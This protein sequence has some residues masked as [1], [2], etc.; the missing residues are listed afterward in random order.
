MDDL[1]LPELNPE[2]LADRLDEAL[3]SGRTTAT[4]AEANDPRIAIA[5][6]LANSRHPEMSPEML[7]RIQSKVIAAH[8]QQFPRTRTSRPQSTLALRWAAAAAMVIVFLGAATMPTVASSVPGDFW[9]PFKRN[10]ENIELLIAR[11][12]VTR[13]EVHLTQAERRINEVQV[14][15]QRQEFDAN[16]MID[17]RH[18]LADFEHEA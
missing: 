16:L 15:L 11:S 6:T 1:Q 14:L 17:A 12:S 9:Y 18:S 10:L 7:A 4:S 8:Q 13:A 2:E 5:L 3:A